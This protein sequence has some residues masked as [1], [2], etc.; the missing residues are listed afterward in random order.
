MTQCYFPDF[1]NTAA[2]SINLPSKRKRLNI[3]KPADANPSGIGLPR[4][5]LLAMAAKTNAPFIRDLLQR[6][7]VRISVIQLCAIREN[8]RAHSFMPPFDLIKSVKR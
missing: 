2:A 1:E 7:G 8:L 5:I 6:Y 4:V 3:L